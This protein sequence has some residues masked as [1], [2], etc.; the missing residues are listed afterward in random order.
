MHAKLDTALS[1]AQRTAGL[2]LFGCD[3]LRIRLISVGELLLHLQQG[4]NRHL[5]HVFQPGDKG[6]AG[7]DCDDHYCFRCGLIPFPDQN[8]LAI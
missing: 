3:D 6:C 4:L 7:V 2:L 8:D 5:Q 1:R